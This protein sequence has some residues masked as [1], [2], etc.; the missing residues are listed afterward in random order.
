MSFLCVP[1]RP[2]SSRSENSSRVLAPMERRRIETHRYWLPDFT[3]DHISEEEAIEETTRIVRE[4]PRLRM[5]SE[6]PPAVSIR[7]CRFVYCVALMAE[8]S[9]PAGEDILDRFRRRGLQ[10]AEVRAACRR[11]CRCGV[12]QF[13]VRRTRWRSFRRWSSTTA[14]RTDSSAIPTYYV[15]RETRK[16]VTV[17][18]NVDGAMKWRATRRC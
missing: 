18:L 11:T 7:Q 12:Q 5:I 13:I 17:A 10:R 14:S 16:H 15:S 9:H 8:E 1:A 4:A 3:K 6:V 2:H